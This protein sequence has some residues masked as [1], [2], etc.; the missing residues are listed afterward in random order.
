MCIIQVQRKRQY[1]ARIH[2]YTFLLPH[3]L[4]LSERETEPARDESSLVVVVN[5][6][7]VRAIFEQVRA[8]ACD[9]GDRA[10]ARERSGGGDP[11]MKKNG[12]ERGDGAAAAVGGGYKLQDR[13]SG[14]VI[15]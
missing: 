15:N 11:R 14:G 3:V 6:L 8:R 9:S 5:R 7:C 4:A 13:L 2:T 10:R 1:S 12:A